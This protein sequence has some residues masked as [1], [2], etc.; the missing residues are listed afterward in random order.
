VTK[1]D[2]DRAQKSAGKENRRIL[3]D[4]YET[5]K[6][7]TTCDF[8][9]L[10]DREVRAR[11][12]MINDSMSSLTEAVSSLKSPTG[13]KIALKAYT[14]LGDRLQRFDRELATRG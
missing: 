6:L 9:R 2:L 8:D 5:L 13:R 14:A 4:A 3:S 11:R 10:A 7:F 12:S 1:D